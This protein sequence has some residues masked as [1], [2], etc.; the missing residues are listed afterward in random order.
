MEEALGYGEG[1]M[2]AEQL[3]LLEL[4]RLDPATRAR[5]GLGGGCDAPVD[6]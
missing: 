2:T 4:E 1:I 6:S 3:A 5:L